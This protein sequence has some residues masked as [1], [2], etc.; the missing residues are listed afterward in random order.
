MVVVS[1]LQAIKVAAP[2]TEIPFAKYT[3]TLCPI[4]A[5]STVAAMPFGAIPGPEKVRDFI[6]S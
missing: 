6:P 2:W 4:A 5:P 1:L 3:S